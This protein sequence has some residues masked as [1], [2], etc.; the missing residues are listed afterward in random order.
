MMNRKLSLCCVTCS[1]NHFCQTTQRLSPLMVLTAREEQCRSSDSIFLQILL[2]NWGMWKLRFSIYDISLYKMAPC[3]FN[4]I[5]FLFGIERQALK[6]SASCTLQSVHRFWH[7][8]T[9]HNSSYQTTMSIFHTCKEMFLQQEKKTFHSC[10][11][12]S[13]STKLILKWGIFWFGR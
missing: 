11:E 10:T 9:A 3:V 13:Y 7:T 2:D 6:E 12:S 4:G 8:K 5:I 1:R